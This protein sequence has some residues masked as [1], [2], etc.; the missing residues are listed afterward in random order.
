ML[1]LSTNFLL[2]GIFLFM[3]SFSG[4]WNLSFTGFKSSNNK[5][6]LG[7]TAVSNSRIQVTQESN[8]A[9]ILTAT[10]YRGQNTA[11][12]EFALLKNESSV[13][14]HFALANLSINGYEGLV[15][16]YNIYFGKDSANSKEVLLG[17]GEATPLSLEVTTKN[18][19]PD[20]FRLTLNFTTNSY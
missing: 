11:Y 14:K 13:E 2:F 5:S 19:G 9:N 18:T 1:K 17:P 15:S 3:V 6:V 7:L 12:H 10:V 20:Y 16:S 4:F 8:G